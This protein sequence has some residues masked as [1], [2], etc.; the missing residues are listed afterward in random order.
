MDYEVELKFPLEDPQP[1]LSRLLQWQAR[2]GSPV[3]Q[4]DHYFDHPGR[5]FDRTDEALRIRTVDERCWL[6]YK[7]PL[8][9]PRTK[10]RREIELPFGRR[11]EDA[12]KLAELLE[13][14]GFREVR[15]VR[16]RRTPYRLD[17]DGL[18]VELALD[19]IDE[20]GTF[21]EI[22]AAAEEP[23]RERITESLLSFA[24]RLGLRG[25]IRQSYL[26]L[27]LQRDRGV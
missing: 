23:E 24:E 19:E 21:L 20:L 1:V 2:P 8:V 16:K 5:D 26:E 17:W 14:L 9:D 15:T 11:A 22:E 25:A 7:G 27:L 13:A 18:S 4:S 10:T 6:T 3:E 12:A